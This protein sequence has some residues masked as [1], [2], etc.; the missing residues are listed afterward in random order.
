MS[1]LLLK[2]KTAKTASRKLAV[3]ST[4]DKNQGLLAIAEALEKNIDKIVQE[5]KKDIDA[6]VANG[7]SQAIIDRLVLNEAR[8]LDMVTGLKQIVELKDPIGEVLFE[9]KIESDLVLQK[10]RVPFGLIGMIYEARPN[11]TIDA[12]GL[13]LKTGN[14]VLLRGGSNAF[15]SNLCLVAIVKEALQETA[16]SPDTIQYIEGTDRK[17]VEEMLTLNEYLDLVI[18]RGGAG[19]IQMV[20]QKATVPVIETGV[21]NCHLYIEKEANIDMA[22]EIAINAKTQRPGVCNA[23]ETIL[24]D[25]AWADRSLVK[26]IDALVEKQVKILG[27]PTSQ[28]LDARISAASDE[29]YYTEFLDYIVT[30][31][32]VQSVDEAIE[33]IETYGSRHSEA[34]ITDND[35]V[36]AKF[37]N[38]VDAAAVYH[39]ASTRFTDGFQYGFGAEIGISTQK[40]HARGPMGLPEMTSYKY[41]VYGKGQ[42]RK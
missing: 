35:N 13:A 26:L 24:V 25:Q 1:E 10:V 9:N 15:H 33:H 2:A 41:R 8:I 16:I 12:V 7:T 28:K 3:V 42:I 21:G 27:C 5:N 38:H 37:L 6:A 14:A 20:V 11:V 31:K 30:L 22:I 17:L 39:N 32:V 23:I 19:L 36:A 18:P 29:D 34:I 40:L 4:E